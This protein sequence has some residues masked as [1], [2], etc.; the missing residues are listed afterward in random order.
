MQLSKSISI[1]E[2]VE[3]S[4]DKS[5]DLPTMSEMCADQRDCG[6]LKLQGTWKG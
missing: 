5:L 1:S 2:M 6:R 3:F 4:V